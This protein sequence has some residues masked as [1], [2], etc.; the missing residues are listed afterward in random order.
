MP[1]GEKPYQQRADCFRL[2]FTRAVSES[3][4]S[5]EAAR[6]LNLCLPSSLPREP[7]IEIRQSLG[8]SQSACSIDAMISDRLARSPAFCISTMNT[9]TTLTV[10]NAP[11]VRSLAQASSSVVEW[12]KVGLRD[13]IFR[14]LEVVQADAN[15]PITLL[16]IQGHSF[17]QPQRDVRQ[18]IA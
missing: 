1:A 3:V 14:F 7:M 16:W 2:V 15:E 12:E 18:L 10:A 4:P 8:S 13:A 9:I 17:S 11:I 6:S 5:L